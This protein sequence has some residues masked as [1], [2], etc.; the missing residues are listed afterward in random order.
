M[1]IS[2]ALQKF[3]WNISSKNKNKKYLINNKLNRLDTNAYYIIKKVV[4]ILKLKKT[5]II[6]LVLFQDINLPFIY[7]SYF[8]SQGR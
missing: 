8:S 1:C 6:K 2:E 5:I 3:A 7:N 4:Y